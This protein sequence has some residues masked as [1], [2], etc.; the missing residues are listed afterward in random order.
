[1]TQHSLEVG[2]AA[3]QTY[4]VDA[5]DTAASLGSGS[6]EVLGTPRL[7]AWMEAQTC[8]AVDR[9]LREDQTSVGTRVEL[10]HLRA[11]AVGA[12]VEVGASVVHVDGRLVRLEAVATCGDAVSG[13]ATVTRVIVDRRRFLDRALG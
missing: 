5:L 12:M 11:C 8:S 1:M 9:A 10:E 7:L 13:R 6:L 4:R 3:A 2:L